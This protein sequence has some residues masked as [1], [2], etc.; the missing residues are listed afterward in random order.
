[1]VEPQYAQRAAPLMLML[2]ST[3]PVNTSSISSQTAL[4]ACSKTMHQL[5]GPSS[6]CSCNS[7]MTWILSVCIGYPPYS[8]VLNAIEQAWSWMANRVKQQRPSILKQLKKACPRSM[9]CYTS[10]NSAAFISHIP[11]VCDR[12]MLI[13]QRGCIIIDYW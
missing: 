1:M 10:G 4:I 5:N 13:E 9:V 8:P 6:P 7:W 12:E 3:S 11:R 2:T